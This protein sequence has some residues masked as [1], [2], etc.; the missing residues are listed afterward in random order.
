MC[1]DHKDGKIHL[2]PGNGFVAHL[3]HFTKREVV[4]FHR[5]FKSQFRF[6]RVQPMFDDIELVRSIA[7]EEV[8]ASLP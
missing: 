3:K 4:L 6:R 2:Q 8:N 7:I 1:M 5:D